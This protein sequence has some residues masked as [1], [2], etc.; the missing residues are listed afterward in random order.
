MCRSFVGRLN[1][2]YGVICFARSAAV[3]EWRCILGMRFPEVGW[4][5]VVSPPKLLSQTAGSLWGRWCQLP[6]RPHAGP[7]GRPS[8]CEELV[9]GGFC[10][11]ALGARKTRVSTIAFWRVCCAP[12]WEEPIGRRRLAEVRKTSSATTASSE[13]CAPLIGA[14]R[15]MSRPRICS[16]SRRTAQ[17]FLT[18]DSTPC[19]YS[20]T[21]W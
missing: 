12:R 15:E 5:T 10:A 9:L 14:R 18:L 13:I 21:T 20:G 19:A 7:D 17:E 3:L 6:A 4:A 11:A 1:G 2:C 16:G 8:F